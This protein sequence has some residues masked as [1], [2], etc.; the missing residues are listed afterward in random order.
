M[1]PTAK[2]FIA[3]SAV[4]AVAGAGALVVAKRRA[5]AGAPVDPSEVLR[6]TRAEDG[7]TEPVALPDGPVLRNTSR[8]PGRM[9]VDFGY[10]T[11]AGAFVYR[12]GL[13]FAGEAETG[14]MD[15]GVPRGATD[16][17]DQFPA[18]RRWSGSRGAYLVAVSHA[19]ARRPAV[20]SLCVRAVIGPT[21]AGFDLHDASLC[22][23]QR[24][25]DGR[26]H[27][28]TLACGLIR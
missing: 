10:R 17:L 18:E 8:D 14:T 20:P 28:T 3:L 23:M 16:S 12:L 22:V 7:G 27:P 2:G 24:D 13:A 9:V 21:K 4:V 15:L 6:A 1:T 25:G 5:P 26:C 19:L 11:G